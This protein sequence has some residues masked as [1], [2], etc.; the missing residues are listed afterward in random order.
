MLAL[1]PHPGGEDHGAV[2][3]E[4]LA[5]QG[6][7]RESCLISPKAR[8]RGMRGLIRRVLAG[9]T[10]QDRVLSD[11][12]LSFPNHRYKTCTW[13]WEDVDEPRKR[14]WHSHCLVWSAASKCQLTP[15]AAFKGRLMPDFGGA[16]WN[17]YWRELQAFNRCVECGVHN[18]NGAA[19][20]ELMGCPCGSSG[21]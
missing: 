7:E 10:V 21:G 8:R 12:G 9:A 16:V 14:Y 20:S 6:D 1:P 13:C 17:A 3:V 15:Y 18:V 5:V 4:V 11:S 19:T 2:L